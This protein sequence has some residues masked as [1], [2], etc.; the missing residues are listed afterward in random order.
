MPTPPLTGPITAF[1]N[2]GGGTVTVTSA[3]TLGPGSV[4]VISGTTNYNGTYTVVSATAASFVIT[5]PFIAET[6]GAT[7]VW[8]GVGGVVVGCTTTTTGAAGAITLPAGMLN[9]ASRFAGVAPLAVFFDASATTATA[10]PV[11]PFHDLGFSWNFGDAASGNWGDSGGGSGTGVN[12]SRN[13]A[14][15]PLAAHVFET[16]GTYRVNVTVTD[17]TNTASNNCIEIAVLDA[18]IVFAGAATTCFSAS[19]N[20]AGCPA[21]ATQVTTSDFKAAIATATPLS[22]LLFARGDVFNAAARPQLNSNGPGIIGAFGAGA[23]PRIVQTPGNQ[24]MLVTSGTTA[25]SDWRIMDLEFDGLLDTLPTGVQ[26]G[27]AGGSQFTLL[28]LSIHD[29]NTGLQFSG[30][31]PGGH[32]LWDQLTIAD[33]VLQR[34]NDGGGGGGLGM[35]LMATRLALLGNL[36][37]DTTGAEHALRIQYAD[38]AVIQANDLGL[39]ATT[40]HALTIRAADVAR[41]TAPNVTQ[42]VV[43][44]DNLNRG[45]LSAQIIAIQPSAATIDERLRDIIVDGNFVRAGPSAQFGI[46]A[47]SDEITVRNNVLDMTGG[48]AFNC[49][50]FARS[51]SEPAHSGIRVYN[52]TCFSNSAGGGAM[53]VVRLDN[54]NTNVTLSNNLGFAPNLTG[55]SVLLF[56]AGSTGVTGGSGTFG[57]ASDPLTTSPLFVNAGGASISDYAVTGA[58]FAIGGG[59]AVPVFTDTFR[60]NRPLGGTFDIGAAEQ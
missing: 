22:R 19:G 38:R 6:P 57:N 47:S 58:S 5:A 51:G 9:V 49:M 30:P 50:N 56:D 40:K 10:A 53:V 31:A 46:I 59:V 35:F 23:R 7:A 24:I 32:L 54:T 11:R 55:S 52:N 60:N 3:N 4:I 16:P 41:F 12:P 21:G 26:S 14:H 37:D 48:V 1:A 39:P 42:K 28:R 29:V 8:A 13:V 36:I 44:T 18:N 43:V 34:I 45:G 27:A 15:G 20:F 17:G 2:A 33:S 25:I